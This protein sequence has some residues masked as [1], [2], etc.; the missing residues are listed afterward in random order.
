[1]GT[2]RKQET[3]S[4][5]SNQYSCWMTEHLSS[6]EH[7][8]LIQNDHKIGSSISFHMKYE[9]GIPRNQ[10]YF[11][12]SEQAFT[13]AIRIYRICFNET[14]Q[15]Q[16]LLWISTYILNLSIVCVQKQ[17]PL[18]REVL[19][20]PSAT[21]PIF[22]NITLTSETRLLTPHKMK[23]NQGK[24]QIFVQSTFYQG[25]RAHTGTR[26]SRPKSS[27]QI[28]SKLDNTSFMRSPL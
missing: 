20:N 25:I 10:H 1:M 13:K 21:W 4:S 9:I 6:V 26:L 18:Y 23:D 17:I 11:Q 8:Q 28:W 16:V 5:A 12:I 24:L 15:L 2:S 22:L 19:V 3:D 7:E 27:I 14:T